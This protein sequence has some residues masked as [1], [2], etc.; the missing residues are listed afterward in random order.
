MD[1]VSRCPS[2]CR[3]DV[4]DGVLRRSPDREPLH[5]LVLGDEKLGEVPFDVSILARSLLELLVQ[6]MSVWPID[7]DLREQVEGR[8][9]DTFAFGEGFDFFLRSG[10]LGAWQRVF[11]SVRFFRWLKA[12]L[13]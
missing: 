13:K 8:S 1:F 5:V 11:L 7:I 4:R 12:F 9:L 2:L 3:L 10:L 6:R